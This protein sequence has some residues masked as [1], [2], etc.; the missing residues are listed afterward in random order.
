MCLTHLAH[1]ASWLMSV[2]LLGTLGVH[3]AAQ[4]HEPRTLLLDFTQSIPRN[5]QLSSVAGMT[6]KNAGGQP[7]QRGYPLPFSLEL[8]SI[9]P[10][11]VSLGEKLT[12]EMV[13]QNIGDRPF[14]L[15]ASRNSVAVFK[16]GNKGQRDFSFYLVFKDS[17]NGREAF[18]VLAVGCGSDAVPGSLLRVE[19]GQQVRILTKGDLFYIRDLLKPGLQRF[20]VRAKVSETNYKEDRYF[21]KSRS[22]PVYSGN[23][24][25]LEIASPK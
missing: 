22:E 15:P 2:I 20:Q 14:Y 9:S 18:C 25:M 11:R 21:I 17:V 5:E 4:S 8:G 3:L 10:P 19:P 16:P 6:G 7:P 13:L 24:I 1:N 23:T 12:V